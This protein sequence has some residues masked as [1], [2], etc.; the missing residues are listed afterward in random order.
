MISEPKFS[1]HSLF[2]GP[3]PAALS[4]FYGHVI[5]I[6]L[7]TD[8]PWSKPGFR[9]FGKVTKVPNGD[10]EIRFPDAMSG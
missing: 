7:K 8:L 1:S 3:S 10:L 2:T 9:C 5:R 6:I 4:N